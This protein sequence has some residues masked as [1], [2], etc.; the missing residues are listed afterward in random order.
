MRIISKTLPYGH[1]EKC[2]CCMCRITLGFKNPQWKNAMHLSTLVCFVPIHFVPESC[3]K[4]QDYQTHWLLNCFNKNC[5]KIRSWK[6]QLFSNLQLNY[7][8]WTQWNKGSCYLFKWVVLLISTI[9][10]VL[11]PPSNSRSP[12]LSVYWKKGVVINENVMKNTRLEHDADG[13][14]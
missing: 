7:K 3:Q 5:N 14:E 11:I 13:I 6:I 8:D 10:S 2:V 9:E 4:E 12:L 1:H